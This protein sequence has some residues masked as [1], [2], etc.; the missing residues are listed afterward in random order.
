MTGSY[1]NK[2]SDYLCIGGH[3]KCAVLISLFLL[4][5]SLLAKGDKNFEEKKSKILDMLEK[6]VANMNEHKACV[7]SA[8]NMDAL[9]VCKEKHKEQKKAFRDHRRA[10]KSEDIDAKIKRLQER[11]AKMQ[12]KN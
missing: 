10:M 8:S 12:S 1:Y 2:A 4:S 5:T 9:K 3:M 6:K 11:K 7:S